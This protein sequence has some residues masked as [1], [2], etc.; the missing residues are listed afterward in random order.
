MKSM[1][2]KKKE[3]DQPNLAPR[4]IAGRKHVGETRSVLDL[5]RGQ[6]GHLRKAP[7][8]LLTMQRAFKLKAK[9]T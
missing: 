2:D 9:A 8:T 7:S 4:S 1:Y 6:L 5:A 3:K